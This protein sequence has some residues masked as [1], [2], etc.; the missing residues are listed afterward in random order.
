M[1]ILLSEYAKKNGKHPD[2]A[3]RLAEQ[4]RLK[5]AQKMGR[6]WVVDSDEPYPDRRM[7]SGKYIGWREKIG[8]KSEEKQE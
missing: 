6:F 4:G 1:N 5:T 2:A 8:K 3:R 7:K